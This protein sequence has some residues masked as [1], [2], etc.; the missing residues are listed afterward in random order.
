MEFDFKNILIGFIIGVMSV[1]LIIFLINDISI[2]IK[3]GDKK[4]IGVLQN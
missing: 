4:E 1:L 2:E 3:I